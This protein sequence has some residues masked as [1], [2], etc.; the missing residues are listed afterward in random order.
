MVEIATTHDQ[1]LQSP[2]T[3]EQMLPHS[4]LAE[5]ARQVAHQIVPVYLYGESGRKLRTLCLLD[6]G[7]N[8]TLV[9]QALAE[10][11]G[12]KGKLEDI[13]LRGTNTSEVVRSFTLGPLGISGVGRRHRRYTAT[14]P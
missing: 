10:K 13:S 8:A 7:S 4:A 6:T 12:Y 14:Q 11:M 1:T 5:I 9:L 3:H 2:T